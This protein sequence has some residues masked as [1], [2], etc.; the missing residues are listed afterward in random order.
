[1]YAAYRIKL[2]QTNSK[3]FLKFIDTILK[4]LQIINVCLQEL[5]SLCFLILALFIFIALETKFKLKYLAE[6]LKTRENP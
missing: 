6:V 2:Q 3:T 5:Y 1:M 4:I